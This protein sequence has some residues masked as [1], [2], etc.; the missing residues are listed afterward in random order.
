[1]T[2]NPFFDGQQGY[3]SPYLVG[4]SFS[5][6]RALEASKEKM[7]RRYPKEVYFV[8][9]DGEQTGGI[10]VGT[11]EYFQVSHTNMTALTYLF[12]SLWGEP[13]SNSARSSHALCEALGYGVS[14][15]T[16]NGI[17]IHEKYDS[18][19]IYSATPASFDAEVA[20]L[21]VCAITFI[22]IRRAK[23]GV[24]MVEQDSKCLTRAVALSTSAAAQLSGV[25]SVEYGHPLGLITLPKVS[26][27]NVVE[28]VTDKINRREIIPN[29]VF[30]PKYSRE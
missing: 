16:D 29:Y 17:T 5:V 20:G 28:V 4:E 15:G 30:V 19:R 25:L 23:E 1:M 2:I 11:S 3:R 10:K 22:G 27:R 7:L 6:L 13:S 26:E 24:V 14:L 12:K 18:I 8:G 21:V 9:V